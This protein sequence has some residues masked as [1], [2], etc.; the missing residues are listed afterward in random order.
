M[1]Q[2]FISFFIC[3]AG[4]LQIFALTPGRRLLGRSMLF[5][6]KFA[7]LNHKENE[8]NILTFG[9]QNSNI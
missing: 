8:N 6:D 3:Q 1:K 4:G 5:L 7:Y 2:W 9:I